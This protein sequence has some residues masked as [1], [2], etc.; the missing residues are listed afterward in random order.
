MTR[1]W[2]LINGMELHDMEVDPG[3]TTDL[4]HLYPEVVR[5][6]RADYDR[7][8]RR[9]ARQMTNDI[10]F[11]IGD[12]DC[13][14]TVLTSHDWRN[15]EVEAVWNQ[16]M[17]RAGVRYNGYWEL[18]VA[19]RGTYRIELRRWPREAN[20]PL[21]RGIQGPLR[22]YGDM[23]YGTGYGGGA[24]IDIDAGVV[25]VGG[26]EQRRE[27]R[28]SDVCARFELSLEP[29][30]AHLQARWETADGSD[31]GAYYVYLSKVD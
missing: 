4:S 21:S 15:L 27:V 17:V 30:P 11:R 3:Q 13:G 24:A 1:R 23:V 6:L 28:K 12:A 26:D 5:E 2:R 20:L 25:S 7:W 22:G 10:P 19:V 8:W 29:G 14:E 18:D 16:S 9:V 31:V